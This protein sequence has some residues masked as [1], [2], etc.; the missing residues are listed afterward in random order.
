MQLHVHV[1]DVSTCKAVKV[2]G[3]DQE[4]GE[5]GVDS[6]S[7]HR[8]LQTNTLNSSSGQRSPR[9]DVERSRHKFVASVFAQVA[10]TTPASQ[11]ANDCST[12][13][14]I[15]TF[16]GHAE[17][18][19]VPTLMGSSMEGECNCD[20]WQAHYLKTTKAEFVRISG[21]VS[22]VVRPWEVLVAFHD[23]V[24]CGKDC[25]P[26]RSARH[27]VDGTSPGEHRRA[28]VD[29]VPCARPVAL[30][31]CGGRP[32]SP[33]GLSHLA[34]HGCDSRDLPTAT[35]D[36][37]EWCRAL[38]TAVLCHL[39]DMEALHSVSSTDDLQSCPQRQHNSL[40]LAAEYCCHEPRTT[41]RLQ[42][43]CRA[44]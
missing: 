6:F 27:P 40:S 17:D 11:C 21:G 22:L 31:V 37:R 23:G 33:R 10:E 2:K 39:L 42:G 24:D 18:E 7:G 3:L 32:S 30:C 38:P 1:K 16:N 29:S 14:F 35:R 34:T 36:C 15:M 12:V 28:V 9:D 26:L 25:L 20:A 13:A 43:Q 8:H 4:L 19:V 5:D 41:D 44:R